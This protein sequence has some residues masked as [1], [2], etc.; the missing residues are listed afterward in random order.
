M[1][2]I[3][4]GGMF[5]QCLALKNIKTNDKN[6]LKIKNMKINLPSELLKY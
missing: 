5:T 3:D 2:T 4:M 1:N 6:I